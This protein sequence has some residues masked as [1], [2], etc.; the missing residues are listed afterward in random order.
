MRLPARAF[1]LNLVLQHA[2]DAKRPHCQ[3]RVRCVRLFIVTERQTKEAQLILVRLTLRLTFLLILLALLCRCLLPWV[4]QCADRCEQFDGLTDGISR[5]GVTKVA[6][7]TT[8]NHYLVHRR[9][10]NHS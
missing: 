9:V 5:L 4:A 6:D 2:C 1:A 3:L 10:P 7:E 8:I